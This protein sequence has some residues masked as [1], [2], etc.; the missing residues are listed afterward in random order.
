LLEVEVEIDGREERTEVG[1]RLDLEEPAA[2]GGTDR[3]LDVTEGEELRARE[4][5]STDALKERDELSLLS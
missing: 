5:D 2:G 3:E 4:K 1:E